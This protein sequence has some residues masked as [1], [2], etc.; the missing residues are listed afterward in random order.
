ML[1]H[2]RGRSHVSLI[3]ATM[4]GKRNCTNEEFNWLKGWDKAGLKVTGGLNLLFHVDYYYYYHSKPSFTPRRIHGQA[5][6]TNRK[7]FRNKINRSSPHTD[8]IHSRLSNAKKLLENRT[9]QWHHPDW[10]RATANLHCDVASVPKI[11]HSI[12]IST[13]FGVCAIGR[14]GHM[15]K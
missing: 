8:S 13:T 10:L 15:I 5:G 6:I 11:T 3:K 9:F 4:E 7:N 12:S 1:N 14:C 2:S